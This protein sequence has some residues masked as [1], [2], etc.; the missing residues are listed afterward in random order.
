LK[1][2]KLFFKRN[3]TDP[4]LSILFL[5]PFSPF[6]SFYSIFPTATTHGSLLQEMDYL[7][8]LRNLLATPGEVDTE[9]LLTGQKEVCHAVHATR[10]AEEFSRFYDVEKQKTFPLLEVF[11]AEQIAIFQQGLDLASEEKRAALLREVDEAIDINRD[12]FNYV[13]KY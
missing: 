13:Y 12:A 9:A 2:I 7:E 6:S 3:R 1:K 10:R 11:L 5:P 4:K 8:G